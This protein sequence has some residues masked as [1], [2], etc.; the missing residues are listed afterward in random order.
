M[1]KK[2]DQ[3]FIKWK[4]DSTNKILRLEYN[5]IRNRTHKTIEKYR[6]KYFNEKINDNK[7][8]PRILWQILNKLSGRNKNSVDE[9]IIKAFKKNNTE[10]KSIADN[11]ATEF[12][13]SVL[14]IMPKCNKRLLNESEYVFPNN[15]SMYFPKATN[16]SV[17]KL[18]KNLNSNKAPGVDNIRSVDIKSICDQMTGVIVKLINTSIKQGKYPEVLKTGI[19]RPIHKKGSFSDYANYR[20]ITILPAID[21][22][23]E[24][25]VSNQIQSFYIKN[26]VLSSTQYGFQPNKSTSQLLSKFT[27]EVNESL[28]DKNHVILLFIDFSKAFDTLRHDT[29]LKKLDDTGIRG[30]LLEWCRDYLRNRKYKVRIDNESSNSIKVTE[31]TAQGSVLGPLH[32]LTYVNDMEHVV[33]HCS[34]YQYAHDTCLVAAHKDVNVAAQWLQEDFTQ[35]SKWA[36]DAGLVLNASK[37]KIIHV[38]FSHLKQTAPVRIIAHSHSCLHSTSPCTGLCEAIEQVTHHTYLGLVVDHRFNWGFH[39]DSVCDKLRAILA[40]FYILKYKIPLKILLNMYV[41]L[42]ESIVAYGITSYGRTFKSYTE[43]I[44]KLQVRLLKSIVPKKIKLKCKENVI[45]L[46]KYC[47]VLP[48]QTRFNMAILIEQFNNKNIQKPI[49]HKITTRSITNNT[50]IVPRARNYYGRRTINYLIPT[51]INEI[52]NNIKKEINAKNYKQKYKNHFHD[53]IKN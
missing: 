53:Y 6:N 9:T 17:T 26:D 27:D 37:T 19:V 35:L 7:K 49:S 10:I 52:P 44:S 16:A 29:L 36:H 33:N 31:G 12:R 18:I 15:T 43:R 5:K 28:N 45:E 3:L 24:K 2:K 4:N 14:K 32:Y 22:I 25:Y 38:H 8:N 51:L 42:A 20:P 34:I 21:K 23:I 13:N 46:F 1:C 40:K 50:L 11:F 41:A 48:V 30:P 47:K 39:V